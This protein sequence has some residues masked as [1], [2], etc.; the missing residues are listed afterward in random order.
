MSSPG[1][2]VLVLRYFT[3][4]ADADK[5]Q[6]IQVRVSEA[7]GSSGSTGSVSGGDGGSSSGSSSS[8]TGEYAAL[9]M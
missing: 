8:S 5:S 4:R 7:G 9:V 1:D 6:E 3:P 2:Y